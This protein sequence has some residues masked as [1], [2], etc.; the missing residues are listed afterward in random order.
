MTETIKGRSPD[1]ARAL[2]PA[3]AMAQ[4]LVASINQ[5]AHKDSV[6][7]VA[8]EAL[9]TLASLGTPSG[10]LAAASSLTATLHAAGTF[11]AGEELVF[12]WSPALG[13]LELAASSGRVLHRLTHP[14]LCRA[15]CETYV[16]KG[17]VSQGGRDSFAA[18]LHAFASGSGSGDDALAA[19]VAQDHLARQASR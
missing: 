7:A 8:L 10:V 6:A 14:T 5:A 13:W 4:S 19:L 1:G 16:G 9:F 3:Y 15:V 2:G 11:A 17:A 18:N 12:T